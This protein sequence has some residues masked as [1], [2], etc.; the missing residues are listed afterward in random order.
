MLFVVGVSL[1]LPT[2][3]TRR[4]GHGG[5]LPL[6]VSEA[7]GDTPLIGRLDPVLELRQDARAERGRV[8]YAAG[9]TPAKAADRGNRTTRTCRG[10]SAS[11]QVVQGRA[12][13]ASP[14]S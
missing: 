2:D 11:R 8:L 13:G 9:R 7:T 10:D 6:P 5:V 4:V 1:P 3:S 14:N 12:T